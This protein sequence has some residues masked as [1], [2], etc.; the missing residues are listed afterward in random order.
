MTVAKKPKELRELTEGRLELLPVSESEGNNSGGRKVRA[1][2]ITADVV[3][4][5]RRIY[6]RAVLSAAVADLNTH[7][8]ESP[9]QG[10]LVLTG[11]SEHPSVKGGRPNL[12]ETV[13]RWDTTSLDTEGRVMLEGT[14]VPTSKGRDILA[15]IEHGVPLGV[16]MRGYGHA[17]SADHAGKRVDRVKELRITGFDFVAEPSDPYA[18]LIESREEETMS[19]EVA[20]KTEEAKEARNPEKELLERQIEEGK[21]A[22]AELEKAQAELTETRKAAAKLE[23]MERAAAVDNAI[24]EA[25]KDLKYGEDLNKLFVEAVRAAKPATPEAVTSLVEAKR[26]EYDAIAAG[27]KLG[28]MGK[29]TGTTIEKVRTGFEESTGLP[30]YLYPSHRFMERLIQFSEA[31]HR[32][33]SRKEL[34]PAE[35]YA[36]QYLE[37]FDNAHR[38]QLMAEARILRELEEAEQVSDLNLPY[39]VNRAIVMEAVPSLV[40]LSVFDFGLAETSPTRVYFE[41][42]SAES[43]ATA[44]VTDETFTADHDTWVSLANKRVQPGTLVVE[45]GGT[46]TVKTEY[47]DYVADYANG[48]IM[49]L[50][51]GTISDSAD[52]DITYTYNVVRAGELA[53]IQRGKGTLSYQT[54]ELAADRLATEI[55]DEAITFASSQLGWDARAKTVGMLIREIREMIDS[56]IM[57]LAIAQAHI[58]A[59][60]G[61]TWTS[62]SDPLSELVEK[63]GVAKVAIQNDYYMP[64]AVLMSV[65]NADRLSNWDGYTAAGAR[66]VSREGTGLLG[67]GDT[68][69]TV[70]ALPVFASTEM[71]DTKILVVNRELVQHRVLSS[72]PMTLKGPYPSFSSNK[73][74]ASEQWYVEEYNQT[75]ALLA[76]KG[77]YV[78]VA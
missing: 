77:A 6:P 17:E 3:N 78:T 13:V 38:R 67:A 54:I 35:M 58:A 66:A 53:A 70:K 46:S 34:S 51:T 16:S 24:T 11:E 22:K 55:S 68:G 43:G 2:G 12:L 21:Q 61:G 33:Y 48:R 31:K 15:L 65:T 18:R 52:L 20:V 59:N 72:K 64:T 26:K 19:D 76:N 10:R 45:L 32:D 29:P 28:T 4:A 37:A 36:K 9:G 63:I 74:V 14:I 56:G 25:T 69:L 44:A 73:L 23:A 49:I 7:L 71:P 8:T 41:A 30:E 57:R 1:I 27:R 50:S 47:T 5:N 60:S 40:A 62:A 75:V 42:Y 39:S